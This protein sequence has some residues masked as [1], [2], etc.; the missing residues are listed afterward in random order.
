VLFVQFLHLFPIESSVPHA[1]LYDIRPFAEREHVLR[2][3][4]DHIEE[5]KRVVPSDRLLV[6][7][8]SE[9]WVPLCAFLGVPVPDEPF[10]RVND[11]AEFKRAVVGISIICWVALL[12]PFA[13]ALSLV[14]WMNR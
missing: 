6:F 2:V 7:Q 9:G 8:V 5:V 11:T 4:R 13:L 14:W 3:F 1:L 10:P 12:L